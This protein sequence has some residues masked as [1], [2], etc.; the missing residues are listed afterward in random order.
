MLIV[1]EALCKIEMQV[2]LVGAKDAEVWIQDVQLINSSGVT[3]V[4]VVERLMKFGG[5]AKLTFVR[6]KGVEG[7]IA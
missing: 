7:L 2:F 6:I 1:Q 5:Y 4:D 3:A